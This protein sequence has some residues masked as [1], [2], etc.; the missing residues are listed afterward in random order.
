MWSPTARVQHN[1]ASLRYR[2][3]DTRKDRGVIEVGVIH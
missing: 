1:R 2:K 3:L